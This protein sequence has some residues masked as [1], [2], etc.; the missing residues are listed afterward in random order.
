MASLMY[1]YSFDVVN[2]VVD[3]SYIGADCI[4]LGENELVY[5]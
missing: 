2:A 1:L 4:E 3:W 5:E